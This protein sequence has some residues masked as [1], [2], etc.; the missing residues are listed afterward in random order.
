MKSKTK[1]EVSQIEGKIMPGTEIEMLSKLPGMDEM[2]A[3]LLG[4]FTSPMAQMLSVLEAVV[5][6]PL[7]LM[8]QKSE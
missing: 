2:R 7:S 5:A 4:L 8:K 6:E 1:L 3:I